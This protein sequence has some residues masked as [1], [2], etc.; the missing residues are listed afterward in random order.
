MIEIPVKN[1]AENARQE[2]SVS[3]GGNLLVMTLNFLSYLDL[4]TW[5]IDVRRDGSPIILGVGLEPNAVIE[6]SVTLG[7]LVLVGDRPTLDNL[8]VSNKLIWAV[9]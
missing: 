9:E 4:P 2:F 3:L 5:T 1:G 8:G 7:K 6:M